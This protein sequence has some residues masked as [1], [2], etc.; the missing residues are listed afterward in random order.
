[1]YWHL[2][3]ASTV[4]LVKYLPADRLAQEEEWRDIG[5][6]Q[7]LVSVMPFSRWIVYLLFVSRSPGWVHYMLHARM[8]LSFFG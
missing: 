5:I 1:M 7:R 3:D 4:K 2:T 6:R 8:V